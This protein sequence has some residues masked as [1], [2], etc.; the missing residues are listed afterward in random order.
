MVELNSVCN[1]VYIICLCDKSRHIKT[2]KHTINPGSVVLNFSGSRLLPSSLTKQ[3]SCTLNLEF[4]K[5]VHQREE[6]LLKI[7]W[8]KS[9]AF[10]TQ[11]VFM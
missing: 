11:K 2:Y 8:L 6:V 3:E 10:D 7:F 4:S 9:L 5:L 1:F